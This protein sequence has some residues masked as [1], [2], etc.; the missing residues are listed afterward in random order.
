LR[1][2]DSVENITEID[3]NVN[4]KALME[5]V[6]SLKQQISSFKSKNNDLTHS[7]NSIMQEEH[8]TN[9]IQNKKMNEP[10]FH[11]SNITVQRRVPDLHLLPKVVNVSTSETESQSNT[12]KKFTVENKRPLSLPKESSFERKDSIVNNSPRRKLYNQ[13]QLS[14]SDM[15]DLFATTTTAEEI[16]TSSQ[17]KSK[18]LSFQVSFNGVNVDSTE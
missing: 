12:S 4:T 8:G 16:P 9:I 1:R 7:L 15:I 14:Y 3:E 2:V 10:K 5:E 18:G 17:T 13:R 6:L 11:S